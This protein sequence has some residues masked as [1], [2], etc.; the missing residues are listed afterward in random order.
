MLKFVG[1]DFP[2]IPRRNRARRLGYVM[3]MEDLKVDGKPMD[4]KFLV[5]HGA[6]YRA[7]YFRATRAW[8][9]DHPASWPVFS[10]NYL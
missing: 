9:E 10:E 6:N 8:R 1:P 3:G 7:G 5:K 2:I 4:N